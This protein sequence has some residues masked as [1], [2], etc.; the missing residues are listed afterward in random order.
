MIMAHG[1]DSRHSFSR[2]MSL[3]KKKGRR[4]RRRRRR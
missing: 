4:K 1:I 2:M 3:K